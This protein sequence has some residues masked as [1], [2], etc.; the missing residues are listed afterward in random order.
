MLLLRAR[1]LMVSPVCSSL[2]RRHRQTVAYPNFAIKPMPGSIELSGSL[3]EGSED[4]IRAGGATL[5]KLAG[6]VTATD[7]ASAATASQRELR[8]LL[9]E[10][11]KERIGEEE[12][13]KLTTDEQN[14][15]THVW[16]VEE[17]CAMVCVAVCACRGVCASRCVCV[18]VRARVCTRSRSCACARA[19][20]CVHPCVRACTSRQGHDVHAPLGKHLYRRRREE[21]EDLAG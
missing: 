19:R 20:A 11:V 18:A 5:A 16:C 3:L 7:N 9:V 14:K 2:C 21:R 13:K 12:Y 17:G 6:G 8:A 15:L 4:H 10:E 1:L